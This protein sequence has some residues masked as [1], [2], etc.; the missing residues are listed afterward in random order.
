MEPA[1][2]LCDKGSVQV[3]CFIG[4]KS[5]Y[6]LWKDFH[7]IGASLMVH[8]MLKLDSQ[9][10]AFAKSACANV[11]GDMGCFGAYLSRTPCPKVPL[12]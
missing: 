10:S 3:F 6:V 12:K 7:V 4:S 5:N 1:S 9:I 2:S 11:W 8:A